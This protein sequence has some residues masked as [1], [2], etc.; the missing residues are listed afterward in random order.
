MQ[1][2][3]STRCKVTTL[4]EDAKS[5]LVGVLELLKEAGLQDSFNYSSNSNN[6]NNNSISL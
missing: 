2:W 3:P 4:V 1:K 6:H 5:E